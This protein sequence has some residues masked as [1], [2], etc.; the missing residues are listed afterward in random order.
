MIR[1]KLRLADGNAREIDG[2]DLMTTGATVP[3]GSVNGWVTGNRTGDPGKYERSR[4]KHVRVGH[5]MGRKIQGLR[6]SRCGSGGDG[7]GSKADII[8]T[9]QRHVQAAVSRQKLILFRRNPQAQPIAGSIQEG[10]NDAG[11]VLRVGAEDR[12]PERVEARSIRRG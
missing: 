9:T 1:G 8:G 7:I 10:K 3:A 5:V 4:G 6:F 2:P 12:D 11:R